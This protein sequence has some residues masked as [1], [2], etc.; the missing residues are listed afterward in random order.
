MDTMQLERFKKLFEEQIAT[1]SQKRV[2]LHADADLRLDEMIDEVDRS[3][4]EWDQAMDIRMR[5]RESLFL[6]KLVDA[7]DRIQK[8]QFGHCTECEEPIGL[9]RLEARPTSELCLDCKEEQE[10]TESQYIDGHQ[11][12]S[13]GELIRFA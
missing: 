3:G 6:K 1:I 4:I 11:H 8:G 5:Y 9:R 13:V 12:K 2:V 10:N 7:L